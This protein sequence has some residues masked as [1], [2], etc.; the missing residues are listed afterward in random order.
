MIQVEQ[1]NILKEKKF[2]LL[3]SLRIIF[4]K[5]KIC[6]GEHVNMYASLSPNA[7]HVSIS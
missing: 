2:L 1:I 3:F 6:Q 5:G 4:L 7:Y